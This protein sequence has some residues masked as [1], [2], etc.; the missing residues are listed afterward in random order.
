MKFYYAILVWLVMGAAL[1]WGLV[2][3]AAHG[4]PW[5]LIAGFAAFWVAVGKLGC[6][7]H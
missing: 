6:Q 3:L 5:W 2:Q 4:N 7:T 1:G